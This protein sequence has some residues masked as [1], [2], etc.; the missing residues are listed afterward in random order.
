[1]ISPE[2]IL[3]LGCNSFAAGH[4]IDHALTTSECSVVGMS[5]SPQ[6]AAR[7]LPYGAACASTGRFTFHQMNVN[8]DRDDIEKLCDTVRPDVVVNFAAQAEVR[9]SWRFPEQ[10]FRTNC[11]SV[12]WLTEVLRTKDYLKRYVAVSTPEVYGATPEKQRE[13]NRYAPSTPYAASKLAGDL[14]CGV[15]HRRYGFPVV[16]TR[17]ANVYGIHQPLYRIIPRTIFSIK[18]GQ[19]IRL[20]NRGRTRRAFIHA[21]DVAD[22]TFRAICRGKSGEVYHCAPSDG[23]RTIAGVVQLICDLMGADFKTMV[24]LV[25][26]NFGQ[27]AVYDLDASKA[28][29]ELEWEPKVRF[30]D[31]VRETI[32]WIEK[33]WDIIRTQ[34]LEY[35][36]RP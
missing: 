32:D 29:R 30:E 14:Y 6:Y 36:H 26:E 25:D 27:D 3:V 21:R 28:H 18:A 23:L 16:F 12:V 35:V 15:L 20:H 1:M 17:A 5:R 10:W 33:N 2:R 7:F 24:E 31:G 22:L 11:Q 4:F 34:P 8:S 13:D 9:N 19:P